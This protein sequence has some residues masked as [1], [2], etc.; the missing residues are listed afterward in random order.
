[1]EQH[2]MA[3]PGQERRS[4]GKKWLFG[5]AGGCLATVVVIAVVIG[6]LAYYGL[7]AVPILPPETFLA[8][9]TDAFAVA[10]LTKDDKAIIAEIE[11]VLDRLPEIVEMS[12][13]TE[14]SWEQQRTSAQDA[15]ASA[16]P[17]QAVLLRRVSPDGEGKSAIVL[18]IRRLSGLLRWGVN[19]S[20][21]SLPAE[22]GT[23]EEYE[24][25]TI[26][27]AKDG[28]SAAVRGNNF[29]FSQD[30]DVIK[31]W[32]DRTKEQRE[33][34]SQAGEEGE[35][36]V[37][38]TQLSDELRR[39]YEGL[40]KDAPVRF[41]LSNQAGQLRYLLLKTT[42][43]EAF[44]SLQEVGLFDQKVTAAAGRAETESGS[45]GKVGMK[46]VCKDAPTASELAGRIENKKAELEQTLQVKE[47]EVEQEDSELTVEF[48]VPDLW[49]RLRK[50]LTPAPDEG[51][52]S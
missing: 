31:H 47:L 40:P 45:T 43:E 12:K 26:G 49:S 6:L 36:P 4:S 14:E 23:L 33:A 1:M 22:G 52:Q 27:T 13:E 8:R 29:M 15:L 18:S 19:L 35:A 25:T 7:R 21:D 9:E 32:I 3:G 46:M 38:A 24:G 30:A 51:K 48:L 16:G 50:A 11:K 39:L 42:G 44:E 5:C 37:P 20:M 17:V 2:G 41:G 34:E 28:G 10:R